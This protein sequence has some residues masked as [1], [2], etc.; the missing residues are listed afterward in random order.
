MATILEIPEWTGSPLTIASFLGYATSV[1]DNAAAVE[2]ENATYLQLQA[3]LHQL[4]T[5]L[6]DF[7][8][9][10][11]S[12]KQTPEITKQDTKRDALWKALWYAWYYI[13]QID[14][15]DPLA[16]FATVL[17]PVMTAYKGMWKHEMMKETEEIKG[18]QRD[19]GTAAM[20]QALSELG[21][22]KIAQGI[23]EANAALETQ[24]RDR[25]HAR[26]AR[27]AEKGGETGESI[28]KQMTPVIIELFKHTNALQRIM[29]SENIALFI[30]NINGVINHYKQVAASGG[31]RSGD[32][33]EPTPVD[34]DV[35]PVEPEGTTEG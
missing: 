4:V 35:T 15:S 7:I 11:R 29:P 18:L 17:R 13:D 12:Y 30:Q 27:I 16:H 8:N 23:F 22:L 19:L 9:Q 34:P 33:P 20:Q 32:E 24:V 26:G 5:R 2:T 25:E 10:Q 1:D 3:Q 6:Q 31:S 21:L 28:R 14:Q